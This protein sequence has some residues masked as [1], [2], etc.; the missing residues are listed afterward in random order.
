MDRLLTFWFRFTFPGKL[1]VPW[2]G[3]VNDMMKA[4]YMPG[5][6]DAI[7][8]QSPLMRLIEGVDA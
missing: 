3:F 5:I 6:V 7:F 4:H 1:T 2:P 8:G